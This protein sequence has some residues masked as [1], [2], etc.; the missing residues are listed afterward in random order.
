MRARRY[1]Y[2]RSLAP[3]LNALLS[4]SIHSLHTEEQNFRP[5]GFFRPRLDPQDGTT[6]AAITRNKKNNRS[7][8]KAEAEDE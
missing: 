7:G 6:A 1:A 2:R 8:K 3:R 5:S 4:I